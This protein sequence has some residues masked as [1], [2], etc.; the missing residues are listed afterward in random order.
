V[1]CP[2]R[3]LRLAADANGTAYVNLRARGSGLLLAR[4]GW[5]LSWPVLHHRHPVSPNVQPALGQP[6]AVIDLRVGLLPWTVPGGGIAAG[7]LLTW[8]RRHR[9]GTGATAAPTMRTGRMVGPYRVL[10]RVGSGGIADIFLAHEVNTE[11]NVALK[12]LQREWYGDRDIREQFAREARI[13]RQLDRRPDDAETVCVTPAF[14]AAAADDDPT[15]WIAMQFLDQYCSLRQLL[16]ESPRGLE[17]AMLLPVMETVAQALQIIHGAGVIHG[18]FTPENV[19]INVDSGELR[20]IDFGGGR[21]LVL[22]HGTRDLFL[23]GKVRY[24][25]PERWGGRAATRA[26]DVY[27]AGIMFGEIVAGHNPLVPQH[28]DDPALIRQCHDTAERR[29]DGV[30]ARSLVLA[31]LVRNM[32]NL[33]PASRPTANRVLEYLLACKRAAG[34][35]TP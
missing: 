20:V 30:V 11:R 34:G 2:L 21:N 1:V 23:L 17:S 15:P 9:G 31:D 13:L 26:S 18:D 7:L 24:L 29:C 32:L 28:L 16:D 27:A 14:V 35:G 8:R 5:R 6:L 19:M 3:G 12:V 33:D 10:H 25:A 4:S 22:G